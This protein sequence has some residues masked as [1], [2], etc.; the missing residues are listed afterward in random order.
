MNPNPHTTLRTRLW[1]LRDD[2]TRRKPEQLRMWIAWHLPKAIAKWAFIRVAVHDINEYPG[3]QT[4]SQ[5]MA[6][7]DA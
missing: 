7:W 6:R 4:V 3:D 1:L 2:W 5:A